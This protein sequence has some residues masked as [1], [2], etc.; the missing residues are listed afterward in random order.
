[1][2]RFVDYR[3]RLKKGRGRVR[4]YEIRRKAFE[5]P[6]KGHHKLEVIDKELADLRW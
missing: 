1:M 5:L 2:P 6:N 3:A 4:R